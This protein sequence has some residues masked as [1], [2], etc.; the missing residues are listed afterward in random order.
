MKRIFI[1]FFVVF[2]IVVNLKEA[3]GASGTNLYL[4]VYDKG[5][6]TSNI[7]NTVKVNTVE[8][9]GLSNT[10]GKYY[11]QSNI[12]TS[13]CYSITITALSKA[14]ENVGCPLKSCPD[15][16]TETCRKNAGCCNNNTGVQSSKNGHLIVH[17]WKT[18]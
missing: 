11:S 15:V 2:S 10:I 14:T 12:S 7:A 17:Y 9:R 1:I 13:T 4:W 16:P 8:L 5:S 3:N 6:R 18:K